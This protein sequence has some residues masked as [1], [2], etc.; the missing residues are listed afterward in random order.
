MDQKHLKV[1]EKNHKNYRKHFIIGFLFTDFYTEQ[2]FN[3]WIEYMG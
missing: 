2:R 3:G 1:K